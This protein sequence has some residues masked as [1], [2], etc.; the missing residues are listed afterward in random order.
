MNPRKLCLRFHCQ[1]APG[2]SVI[3]WMWR[4]LLLI[5]RSLLSSANR[6]QSRRAGCS[7]KTWTPVRLQH[8]SRARAAARILLRRMLTSRSPSRNRSHCQNF[9]LREFPSK[10]ATHRNA[11]PRRRPSIQFWAR[12]PGCTP[13]MK[14]PLVPLRHFRTQLLLSWRVV[15]AVPN[16]GQGACHRV[17]S[18]TS[19]LRCL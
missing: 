19:L 15:G 11:Q 17:S 14:K 9:L 5:R 7:R 6:R 4:L 13:S 2:C 3:P 16:R 12:T 1:E 8:R 18:S 10:L